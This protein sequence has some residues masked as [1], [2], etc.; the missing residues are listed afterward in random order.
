MIFR[1]R[2]SICLFCICMGRFVCHSGV[3]M[4]W[5]LVCG[6]RRCVGCEQGKT[7]VPRW[8]GLGCSCWAVCGDARARYIRLV[9]GL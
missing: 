1:L 6:H 2:R 9:E 8:G 4:G 7:C 3:C 5:K